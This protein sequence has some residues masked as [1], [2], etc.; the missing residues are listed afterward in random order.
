MSLKHF[1]TPS[2]PSPKFLQENFLL[3]NV[4]TAFCQEMCG[5]R[6]LRVLTHFRFLDFFFVKLGPF[7][8][9]CVDVL[10]SKFV[11]LQQLIKSRFPRLTA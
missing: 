1:N 2:Q 3:C 11:T 10:G 4:E 8:G 9:V 6:F 5:G 7:V